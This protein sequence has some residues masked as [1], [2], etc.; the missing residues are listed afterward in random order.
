MDAMDEVK[1]E[2]GREQN[3]GPQGEGDEPSGG[4][5]R[6]DSEAKEISRIVGC[7][8]L[9]DAGVGQASVEHM[10][11][12]LPR[13]LRGRRTFV[14]LPFSSEPKSSIEAEQFNAELLALP[15]EA[16]E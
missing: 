1:R 11:N 5:R 10:R 2:C 7:I 16:I 9:G 13:H 6:Y 4:K 3:H 12:L 15:L 8:A 14:L